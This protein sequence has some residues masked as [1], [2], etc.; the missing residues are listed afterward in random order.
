MLSPSIRRGQTATGRLS[1]S[2]SYFRFLNPASK[3]AGII[4]PYD[5]RR[6]TEVIDQTVPEKIREAFKNNSYDL[7]NIVVG[8]HFDYN[9]FCGG[10]VRFGNPSSKG[11]L[12]YLIFPL[13][14]RKLMAH[15][16]YEHDDNI[17]LNKVLSKTIA[18]CIAVPLEI[19][20]FSLGI[21][22]TLALVP[23]VAL[24]YLVKACLPKNEADN[25]HAR[26]TMV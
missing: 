15:A 6:G 25:A 7:W 10:A 4:Y 16:I 11:I 2:Q 19:T 8:N 13:L 23:V 5:E 22:L 1:N 12:D 14:A 24:I 9:F 21:A 18:F 17:N 20:R 26:I 3:N